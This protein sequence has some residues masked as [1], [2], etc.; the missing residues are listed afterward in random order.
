MMC[1]EPP[2]QQMQWQGGLARLH[3]KTSYR[4]L[5]HATTNTEL[6]RKQRMKATVPAI[7]RQAVFRSMLWNADCRTLPHLRRCYGARR[8]VSNENKMPDTLFS[9]IAAAILAAALH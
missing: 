4:P 8:G 2:S 3:N 9:A 5:L 7:R 6:R 1:A